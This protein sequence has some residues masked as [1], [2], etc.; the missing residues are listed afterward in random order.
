MRLVLALS[1]LIALFLNMT[2]MTFT[3]PFVYA[4]SNG[5]LET[6]SNNLNPLRSD[7]NSD[8]V[9]DLRDVGMVASA[10][11]TYPGHPKW[12][13][14]F[15]FNNDY[16]VSM[17]D[18]AIVAKDFGKSW[19]CHDFNELIDLDVWRVVSGTWSTLAGSLEGSSSSEG[20]IY[21]KD[22]AWKG[23]TLN[24]KVKI[25]A[26]SPRPEVA[27]CIYL[28]DSSN[29][30]WA[31]LGC[32]G[33]RV[34]ISRIVN[35]IAEELIFDGNEADV[36]KD[37][38]YNLS[39]KI[40]HDQIALYVND[41]LELT[42]TDSTLSGGMVGIGC[43]SS[44]VL[45]D[46]LVVSGYASRA[47]EESEMKKFV[48]YYPGTITDEVAQWIAEH[49][50]VVD[51]DFS[52][53]KDAWKIKDYNPNIIMIGYRAIMSMHT[54]YEDWPEVNAH[55]DWFLHDLNEKRL[56]NK[57][58]GWY[59]MD[60][61]NPGWRDH[62]AQFVKAKLDANPWIDGLFADNV[63]SCRRWTL[64]WWPG[65][66]TV[67]DS[68]VP[69][70]EIGARWDEDMIGMLKHVKS[71]LGDKLVIINTNDWSTQ[72]W[73]D[74]VGWVDSPNFINY[75]DGMMFEGFVH[76]S[77]NGWDRT[78]ADP[79]YQIAA[80]EARSAT[81]KIILP[82]TSTP[83]PTTLEEEQLLEQIRL[84]GLAST[85][86]AVNG[87]NVYYGFNMFHRIGERCWGPEIDINIGSPIG[88][89]YEKDGLHIREFDHGWALV[90]F[91][92][93][94]RSTVIDGT[95]YTLEPRSGIVVRK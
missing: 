48:V 78:F 63:W 81:G 65:T 61:G 85:L 17:V 75:V 8:G 86:L 22:V 11:S 23:C 9:V 94:T 36:A 28:V 62:F 51:F 83:I 39:I 72:Y 82:L 19:L 5:R 18:L 49:F 29:Y 34:S 53:T 74:G 47:N 92:T 31:G 30:Y 20:L 54:T 52:A 73:V 4:S 89:R 90:N 12:N 68:L 7:V 93:D 50:D 67:D 44:H 88:N 60:V 57:Q 42:M 15:D 79:Y 6:S 14:T 43:S 77:W 87:P 13:S 2:V 84:Y 55:E 69:K 56:I 38:W 35:G 33:H 46:Y 24:A 16:I 1:I 40:S 66:W 27:F 32:W 26:D 64:P 10:F 70:E 71:V 3:E 25:A 37:T 80:M 58:C 21:A 45:V 91:S 76:G 95:T 59:A 41:A